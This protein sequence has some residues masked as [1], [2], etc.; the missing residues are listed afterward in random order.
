[1]SLP[2]GVIQTP[3]SGTSPDRRAGARWMYIGGSTG[4]A[5]TNL[6]AEHSLAVTA[7]SK[8]ACSTR[9]REL[10]RYRGL[11]ARTCTSRRRSP[12][13]MTP[14]ALNARRPGRPPTS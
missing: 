10:G 8:P 12:V 3:W 5:T 13:P 1:M 6:L 2:A 4:T 7:G 11:G 14:R 9:A